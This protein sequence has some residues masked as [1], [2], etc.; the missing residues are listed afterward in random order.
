[1]EIELQ[2]ISDFVGMTHPLEHLNQTAIEQSVKLTT[3]R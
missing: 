1:M 2:E 3:N